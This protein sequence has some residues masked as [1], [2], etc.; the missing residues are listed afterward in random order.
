[1][2]AFVL[3]SGGMMPMPR[4]RLTAVA[5]RLGGWVYLF[6][7]GEGTQVPYKEL[8]L[9]QRGLRLCAIT[10]L[11]ADHCLGLPGMLMLR[12][13]MPDPEPLTLVG[14]PGL[15]R[16]V[17]DVR[18][19]L[20]LYINYEIRIEEWKGKPDELELAYEDEQLRLF[21]QP[22]LHSVFCLGYRLEERDRPGRFDPA[23]A[24]ALGVPFGPLRGQLQRGE[25]VVTPGGATVQPEQVLGPR[26][27]G[28]H[29][30]FITD[31]GLAPSLPALLRETDLSFVEGM[32]LSEHREEALE[33]KHLT[34]EQ[35][36][37]AAREAGVKRLMLVHISPRYD[38]ADVGRLQEEASQHHP[39][40]RVAR[41]GEQLALPFPED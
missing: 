13:Q 6:D 17:R 2:E 18:R 7:C 4:R 21:W 28:R 38:A 19:D 34:V 14:P 33:K 35:A 31:T 30:A 23:A 41:D 36:A 15:A 10:H 24:D 12:A 26:R 1:M 29:L 11:H 39:V 5:L 25:S 16:F 20:A 9:G 22:V 3:G 27:R 37:T 32:F 8:H 40:A